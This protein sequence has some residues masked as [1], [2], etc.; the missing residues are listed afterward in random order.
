MTDETQDDVQQDAMTQDTRPA[1]QAT[2]E[3]DARSEAE[4]AREVEQAHEEGERKTR[5]LEEDPPEKLEDWPTD[6]A[7]YVTFGGPAGGHSY[8]EGPERKL[9]PSGLRHEEGGGVRIDGEEVDDPDQ[10]KAEPIPGGPTD[11]NAPK[12]AGEDRGDESDGGEEREAGQD[13]GS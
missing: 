6:E 11:P 3:G 9:G 2:S 8:D 7:K 12:L 4:R 10:F 13:G 5:E 1:Q